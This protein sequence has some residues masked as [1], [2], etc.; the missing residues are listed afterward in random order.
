MVKLLDNFQ[1]DHIGIAVKDLNQTLKTYQQIFHVEYSHRKKV[2]SQQVEVAILVLGGNKIELLQTTSV[3][4][5]IGRFID[6]KGEGLHHI[7]YW[8][9]DLEKQIS[10]LKKQGVS[11]INSTPQ[12]GVEGQ[13]FIF[14]NPKDTGGVLIELC[15]RN[16]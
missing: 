14:I 12:V 7:A 16:G 5:P 1:L 11:L 15:Q 8:V 13:S 9:M 6:K 3:D 10:Q 2:P 4:G